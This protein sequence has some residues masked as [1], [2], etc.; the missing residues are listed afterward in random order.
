MLGYG[1]PKEVEA[2]KKSTDQTADRT[3]LTVR[4]NTTRQLLQNPTKFQFCKQEVDWSGF[5]ITKDGVKP[6]P[7]I[8]Q[9]IRDFPTPINRTD[10]RSFLRYG[11]GT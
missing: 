9:S 5:R 2:A 7:H 10:M 8:S 3:P 11:H 1:D 4:G 6:M